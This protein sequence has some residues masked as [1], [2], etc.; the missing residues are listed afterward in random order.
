MKIVIATFQ[1][2]VQ[3][4]PAFIAVFQHCRT[5]TLKEPACLDFDLHIS[6]SEPEKLV[7][8]E[9][10]H[11][12][13]DHMKHVDTPYVR[14]AIDAMD[15]YARDRTFQDIFADRVEVNHGRAK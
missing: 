8:V 10:F 14:A 4:Q 1:V 6:T 9:S 7:V 13:E 5:E 12:H 11:T 15:K 3:D 2:A